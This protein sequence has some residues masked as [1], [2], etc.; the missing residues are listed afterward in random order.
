MAS[1]AV[2]LRAAE[3]STGNVSQRDGQAAERSRLWGAD[4][5]L[6]DCGWSGHTQ[7]TTDLRDGR[8]GVSDD[9]GYLEL[10]V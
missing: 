8:Y 5:A 9:L 3:H 6:G 2:K 7:R 4:P 10:G 1:R